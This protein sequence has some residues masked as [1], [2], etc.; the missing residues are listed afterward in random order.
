MRERL[1]WLADHM[2]GIIVVTVCVVIAAVLIVVAVQ[3]A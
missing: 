1:N 2:V 3:Y